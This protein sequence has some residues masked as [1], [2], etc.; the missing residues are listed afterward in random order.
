MSKLFP[1]SR[2]TGTLPADL[3]KDNL[4]AETKMDGSRY[5]LYLGGCDPYERQ[6]GNALLSRRVSVKDGKHVDRT[7]NVPHFTHIDYEGLEGTVLDG[8]V[9]SSDFLKTNSIMNSGPA[10]AVAKQMEKGKLNYHVF[11]CMAFRGEDIRSLPL[12]KRRL[13]LEEVIRRMD[14]E[15]VRLI[16]QFTS[17]LTDHFTRIVEDGGEGIIVKDLRAGYGQQWAK[18]KKSYDVSAIVSG[19]KPGN[20]KY[21][22]MIGALALSVYH[23]GKL[24]EI[25]FASGFN[26]ALRKKMSDNFE[27]YKGKVVDVFA[28][29]IQKK[30]PSGVGRLRHPT[31]YRFRDDLEP[32]TITSEKLEED[33][34]KRVRSN[35]QKWSKR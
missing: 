21:K 35:R 4:V 33:L 7:D 16:P 8:E 23:E 5:V 18:M 15:N 24:I 28:Q 11:D 3:E 14:N 27:E 13:V 29:E 1:P 34:S 25:G 31:F 10:L 2:C 6:E 30:G 9:M 32:E 12:E 19:Y 20:G 17:N 22:G 26:D